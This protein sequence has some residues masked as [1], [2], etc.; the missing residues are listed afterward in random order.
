ML[1]IYIL[2]VESSAMKNLNFETFKFDSVTAYAKIESDTL[3]KS[4]TLRKRVKI[5]R[6]L[7][8]PC[9]SILLLETE[10]FVYLKL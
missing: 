9:P 6:C 5:V 10:R 3:R 8:N 7:N 2:N 4:H 1:I